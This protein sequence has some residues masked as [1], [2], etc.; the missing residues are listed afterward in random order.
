MCI[1]D[2]HHGLVAAK[3]DRLCGT[4][5]YMDKVSVGATIN[6]M[7]AAA[8]AEGKTI[9]ENAAKEPHVV[10]V[11]NF[12]NRMGANIR[13]AGTDVIRISGVEK[14]H[15][16]EYSIIPDQ[17]EAGTFMFAAAAT[18]GDVT[19]KNV[20]PK[21]CIRDSGSAAWISAAAEE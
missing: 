10:D 6:I 15:K 18:H 16:T 20:I 1:R 5:I 8:M 11:A 12:L 19:V 17:I 2:S 3:A 13:G 21:M 7:M 4:H 9:I 14:L